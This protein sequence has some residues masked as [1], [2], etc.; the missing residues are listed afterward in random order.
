LENG[1]NPSRTSAAKLL[2]FFDAEKIE[3]LP[4][5]ARDLEPERFSIFRGGR[6]L[7]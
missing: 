6:A 1:G 7:K 4:G 5:G 3:M 2:G